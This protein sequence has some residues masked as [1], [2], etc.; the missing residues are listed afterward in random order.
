[1][2]A[3]EI[4]L[5][6]ERLLL[7]PAGAAF[8]PGASLLAVADLHLEK[9]SAAARRGQLV[10]PWDSALT[11]A[12][13]AALVD[14]WRPQVVVAVGDSFED[15][16][17]PARL[18]QAE[19]TLVGAMAAQARFVWVCGN[20]DPS[21]PLDMPGL[22]VAAWCEGALLFRHQASALAEPGEVSGHF[23]PKA[24][25]ATRAG[26]VVRPCF[27]TDGV[28]LV[29]PAFGAYTGGLDVRAPALAAVFPLGGSVHLLGQAKIFSF[30]LPVA[31]PLERLV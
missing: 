27:V 3:C 18:G 4:T 8:W 10:P 12:R 5:H 6:G 25:V 31:L 29:L 9:G 17:G 22:S 11:L 19:R 28:R 15:D 23:H 30:A 1:M 20:H 7:D 14:R 2:T 21:P 13:L 24:R 16:G 26:E